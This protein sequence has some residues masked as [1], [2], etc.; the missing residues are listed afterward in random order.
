MINLNRALIEKLQEWA[1]KHYKVFLLHEN[2]LSN[3]AKSV[4]YLKS[5][6]RDIVS[7]TLYSQT[8][9][10]PC[11]HQWLACSPNNILTILKK[12]ENNSITS[13]NKSVQVTYLRWIP[14]MEQFWI[15][16]KLIRNLFR[17][18]FHHGC[19]FLISS[20]KQALSVQDSNVDTKN[21]VYSKSSR[22]ACAATFEW[23]SRFA[24][25]RRRAGPE[26][27]TYPIPSIQLCISGINCLLWR[28]RRS[29]TELLW[30][31]RHSTFI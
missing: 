28:K 6:E 13:S 23:F 10:Y 26:W 8:W 30:I 9:R 25:W 24:V 4:K 19:L 3:T 18:Q 15:Q 2:A 31:I 27:K 17:P 5:L 12:F 11:S 14:I 1:R 7:R 29:H 22:F 20:A 16:R 21:K